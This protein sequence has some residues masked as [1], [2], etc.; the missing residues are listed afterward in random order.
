MHES[1]RSF[2]STGLNTSILGFGVEHLKQKS[3]DTVQE[4][5]ETAINGGVNYID[6][7]WSLPNIVQGV[8][9]A[10]ET[11]E[12]EII[13]AIHLGSAHRNGKYYRT[14]KPK[15][16]M[17]AYM[18]VHNSLP[19]NHVPIINLHYLSKMKDWIQQT[20][21]GKL[22]DAAIQLRDMG[23]GKHIA[24]STHDPLVVQQAAMHP[25]I[26][27][28]MYQ[29]NIS[30]HNIPE[31]NKALAACKNF[32]KGLVAMKPY[33]AGK[34]LTTGRKAKI[35]GYTRGGETIE[36]HVPK[37]LTTMKLLKYVLNQPAVSCVVSGPSNIEEMKDNLRI[38]TISEIN[39]QIELEDIT[40]SIKG[41]S[42][43]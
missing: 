14:R 5:T 12:M 20:K 3:K 8:A 32:N 34:L 41:K 16:C 33:A 37:T 38:F 24:V 19:D 1:Y 4:I 39:Y 22:M 10:I 35:A 26:D 13:T 7:V 11:T 36:L 21:S 17:E 6:L 9:S 28:I 42:R 2:G 27:S 29:I 23:Y 31:R 18:E 40:N 30:N 43:V 15:E 25:E